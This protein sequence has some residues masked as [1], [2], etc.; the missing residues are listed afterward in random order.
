MRDDPTPPRRPLWKEPLFLAMVIPVALLIAVA[1]YLSMGG[2]WKLSSALII[3]TTH[4][5]NLRNEMGAPVSQIIV[6]IEDE[7]STI[8]VLE[9]G[10]TRTV[11]MRS[12][13]GEATWTIAQMQRGA[14]VVLG[15]CGYLDAMPTENTA[16]LVAATGAPAGDCAVKG[17]LV[18]PTSER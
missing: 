15:D 14:Y 10:E 7:Q 3:G 5:L 2:L 18:S 9:A 8:G 13:S 12:R 6:G 4:V 11:T 16:R 1:A 17:A